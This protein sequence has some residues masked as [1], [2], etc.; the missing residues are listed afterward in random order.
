M[1]GSLYM[2]ELRTAAGEWVP[3]SGSLG[4]G[5]STRP[6]VAPVDE[7]PGPWTG[8]RYARQSEPQCVLYNSARLAAL[9][10]E[11]SVP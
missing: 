2:Y 5:S 3:A 4:G 9:P 10:F 1:A 11:L 6:L 8:V 7:R